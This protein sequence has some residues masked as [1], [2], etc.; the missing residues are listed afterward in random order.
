MIKHL[1]VC[2]YSHKIHRNY[3]LFVFHQLVNN[4]EN[5]YQLDFYGCVKLYGYLS[6]KTDSQGN[7]DSLP[8][9]DLL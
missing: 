6:Y 5:L 9:V 3:S 2:A 7:L 4:F 8:T 1:H